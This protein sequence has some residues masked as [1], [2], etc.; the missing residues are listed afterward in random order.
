MWTF[1]IFASSIFHIVLLWVFSGMMQDFATAHFFVSGSRLANKELVCAYLPP[2]VARSRRLKPVC[3]KQLA[4]CVSDRK[5]ALQ[6][7]A[8]QKPAQDVKPQRQSHE[9]EPEKNVSSE[10]VN[11]CNVNTCK[12]E[13]KLSSKHFA[14]NAVER[15]KS[16]ARAKAQVALECEIM[17]LWSPPNGVEDGTQAIV[18]FSVD[19]SG[20]V[21][22]FDIIKSSDVLIYDLSIARIA[23]AFNFE[24]CLWGKV[25]TVEFC[26]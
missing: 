22:A 23:L 17:R 19:A 15:K 11:I 26:L 8:P 12:S 6:K 4:S 21:S 10:N 24:K 20:N 9:L 13:K 14:I 25:F 16:H 18:Q 5:P 3:C 1:A 7:P 2:P